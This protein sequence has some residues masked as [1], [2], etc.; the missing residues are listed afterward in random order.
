MVILLFPTNGTSCHIL[1]ADLQ[2]AFDKDY[3]AGCI[4]QD[5]W[6]PNATAEGILGY[7]LLVQTGDMDSPIDKTRVI[8]AFSWMSMHL[9][10]K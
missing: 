2:T 9:H 8:N 7:K 5:R 10:L 1:R 4:T 6:Y 3:E